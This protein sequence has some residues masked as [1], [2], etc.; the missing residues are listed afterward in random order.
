MIH[1]ILETVTIPFYK[2]ANRGRG[3]SYFAQDYKGS[4]R[5]SQDSNPGSLL[6]YSGLLCLCLPGE[7]ASPKALCPRHPLA[8]Q[9]WQGLCL[10]TGFVGVL[11]AGEA[12]CIC[13]GNDG[14][15]I[16]QHGKG[17]QEILTRQPTKKQFLQGKGLWAWL[18][19]GDL[20]R[21]SWSDKMRCIQK[22]GEWAASLR[23]RLG[24]VAMLTAD[25]TPA[26]Q[27]RGALSEKSPQRGMEK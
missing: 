14:I 16:T 18:G 15:I 26:R 4:K 25:E 19:R 20:P 13:C 8:D 1:L 2:W 6:L 3:K 10:L 17:Q 5:Y 27:T 12:W 23:W 7:G 21:G 22:D 9:T 11:V 24:P